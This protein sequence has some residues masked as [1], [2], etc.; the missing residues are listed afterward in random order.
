MAEGNMDADIVLHCFE[1]GLIWDLDMSDGCDCY[2]VSWDDDMFEF[3]DD[4]YR[5]ALLDAADG[6]HSVYVEPGVWNDPKLRQ[7]ETLF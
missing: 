2:L 7:E 6:R 1:C 3:V 4:E 5:L